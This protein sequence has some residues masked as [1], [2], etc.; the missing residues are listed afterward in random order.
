MDSVWCDIKLQGTDKLLVGCIYRNPESS[1]PNSEALLVLLNKACSTNPSHLAIVGDFNLKSIDCTS[2]TAHEPETNFSNRFIE[3]LRDNLMAQHVT[4]PTRFRQTR[5]PILLDLVLSNDEHI[6]SDVLHTAP[7]GKSDHESLLFDIHCSVDQR[8][9][10]S[11]VFVYHEGNYHDL[12]QSL[13]SVKWDTE[14]SKCE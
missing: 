13:S 12:R 10:Q 2:W 4:S 1:D 14:L 9:T 8:R 3:T 5:Q 6:I 7:P 11:T